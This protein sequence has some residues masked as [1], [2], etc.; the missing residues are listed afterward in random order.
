MCEKCPEKVT[1]LIAHDSTQFTEDDREWLNELPEDMLD[2]FIP[3]IT[4]H[5]EVT[6]PTLD[7]AWEIIKAQAKPEDYLAHLPDETKIQIN[8]E[9]KA[10]E[11]RQAIVQNILTNSDWTQEELNDMSLV[12]LKKVEAQCKNSVTNY[13]M[14]TGGTDKKKVGSIAPMPVPGVEFEN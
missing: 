13:S 3:K 9:F 12:V 1:A 11:E 4:V 7:E 8:A 14:I 6:T 5:K 10:K 2:K